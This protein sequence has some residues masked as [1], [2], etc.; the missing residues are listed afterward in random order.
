M[1]RL[2]ITC[3]VTQNG[4]ILATMTV[5]LDPV[6][7]VAVYQSMTLNVFMLLSGGAFYQRIDDLIQFLQILCW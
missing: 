3:L 2:A 1:T 6:E 4:N 5:L 7:M